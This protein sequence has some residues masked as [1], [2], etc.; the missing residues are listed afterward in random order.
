MRFVSGE[1]SRERRRGTGGSSSF[2][3]GAGGHA[4][5]AADNREPPGQVHIP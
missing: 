3:Q 4:S 1:S 5:V 2:Q